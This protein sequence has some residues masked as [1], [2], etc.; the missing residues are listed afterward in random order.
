MSHSRKREGYQEFPWQSVDETKL[1][2]KPLSE[3]KVMLQTEGF[4]IAR[5]C[6]TAKTKETEI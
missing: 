1:G 4:E 5:K 6:V 2:R 3:C